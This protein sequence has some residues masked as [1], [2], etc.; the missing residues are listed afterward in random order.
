MEHI[1]DADAVAGGDDVIELGRPGGDVQAVD[2]I[3]HEVLRAGSI[4]GRAIG[5]REERGQFG[6][7][8]VQ[9]IGRDDVAGKRRT[10]RSRAIVDQ[11]LRVR[12][13]DGTR[14]V[15]APFQSR[16]H[17]EEANG[18]NA[19]TLEFNGRDKMKGL[20]LPELPSAWPG[21][22]YLFSNRGNNSGNSIQC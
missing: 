10:R 1:A 12:R 4:G 17:G 19:L 15:A 6:A 8:G 9:A 21:Q 14:K 3:R 5:K 22:C 16:G 11:R 13:T 20:P 7:G 2:G 18:A